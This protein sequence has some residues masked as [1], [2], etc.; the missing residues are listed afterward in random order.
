MAVD[1]SYYVSHVFFFVYGAVLLGLFIKSLRDEVAVKGWRTPRCLWCV[2]LTTSAFIFVINQLDPRGILGLYPTVAVKVIE[3][4]EIIV[5]S[6]SFAFTG[7]VYLIALYRRNMSDV[8]PW[9]RSFWLIFNV[10]CSLL[11]AIFLCIATVTN[12]QFWLGVDGFVLVAQEITMTAVLNLGVWKLSRYLYQLMQ[13]K[14]TLGSEGSNFSNTFRKM[15]WVHFVTLAVTVA[16]VS[17][18]LFSPGAAITR[19]SKPFTPIFLDNTVFS[20]LT[21]ISP[22]LVCTLLSIM[23]YSLRRPQ[24]KNEKTS[25]RSTKELSSSTKELSSSPGRPSRSSL[26]TTSTTSKP[27]PSLGSSS[28]PNA[29]DIPIIVDVRA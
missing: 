15:R 7:Y 5:L 11:H 28:V 3:Y 17:Y 19:I 4:T 14:Q 22:T 25:E 9:L 6:N 16:A 27:S 26:L 1:P 24:S 23:L 29:N 2:L 10:G 13:E 20:L 18:Q 21:V 12:N 8:H